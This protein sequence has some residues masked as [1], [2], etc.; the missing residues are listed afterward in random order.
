MI[1]NLRA[2]RAVHMYRSLPQGLCRLRPDV[3]HPDAPSPPRRPLLVR[4][5]P[6]ATALT[7]H[8]P[9]KTRPGTAFAKQPSVVRLCQ[10]KKILMFTEI[11]P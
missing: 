11:A 2:V 5:P 6:R 3:A 1:S 9:I 8:L 10:P 7:R 4:P